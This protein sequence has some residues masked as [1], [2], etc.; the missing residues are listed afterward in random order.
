MKPFLCGLSVLL[1][2]NAAPA[3]E[4]LPAPPASLDPAS[5]NKYIAA[6]V[7]SGSIVGLSAAIAQDGVVRLAGAYGKSSLAS[8]T[9]VTTNTLFAVGSVTKQFTAACILLLAQEGALSVNDKVAKYYPALTRARDISLLDLMNHVSGYADYY[10]LDFVDSRMESPIAADDLV[11]QYAGRALDF[12]PG[13]QWSYSN[14][15]YVILGR[16]VEKAG[17]QPLGEFMR[18]HIFEPLGMEHS[19]FGPAVAGQDFAQGYT[20]FALGPPAPA[21][22][23]ARG[24]LEGAA[25]LSTTALDLVKWDMA[26][27][28]GRVLNDPSYALMTTP[29]QLSQGRAREYGCGIG[30]AIISNTIVLRHEG[31]ISGFTAWNIIVPATRSA[32]VVL[33]N[34]EEWD[35][36]DHL[37]DVLANLIMPGPP[38]IPRIQGPDAGVA[39]TAFVRALQA[40]RVDRSRLGEEFNRYLTAEKVRGAA[41]RLKSFRAPVRAEVLRRSERGG[42]EVAEVRLV[43]KKGVLSVLL[44]RTPD[45][46][47]QECLIQPGDPIDR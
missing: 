24:W 46:R 20:R 25:G 40:G 35:A 44:Y 34:C 29:R 4:P 22:T 30:V 12:E 45:G 31:Q 13:T 9:P 11:A 2:A 19:V 47:I 26:L 17:G 10:P 33:S 15:G 6:T 5:V 43:C 14:T 27:I 16:V 36:L 32:V 42:M 28:Q 1:L 7:R 21:R 3:G 41:T 8:G 23:E 38:W 37:K 18:R 39:A